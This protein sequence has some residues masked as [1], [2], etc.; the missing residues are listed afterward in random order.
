LVPDL[1]VASEKT[2]V[3]GLL[4]LT[5]AEVA[6]EGISP[7]VVVGVRRAEQPAWNLL[8]QG[9]EHGV[10]DDL[11]RKEPRSVET[12]TQNRE[13]E[14]PKTPAGLRDNEKPVRTGG[15][16]APNPCQLG[17]RGARAE[18]DGRS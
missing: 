10:V 17:E 8:R 9:I 11:A 14:F 12:R 7:Q 13:G 2:L 15:D 4:P 18:T 16:A 6:A 5:E 1:A 3:G